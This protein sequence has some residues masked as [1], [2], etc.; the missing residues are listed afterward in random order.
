V[1]PN[2]L[3]IIGVIFSLQN[4]QHCKCT[5]HSA[6]DNSDMHKSLQTS[7]SSIV[8]KRMD[9]YSKVV[10]VFRHTLD[11]GA[12]LFH[13]MTVNRLDINTVCLLSYW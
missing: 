13:G 2:N 7:G 12:T 10:T 8:G 11:T 6:T 9:P 3:S 5:E 1:A 4:V